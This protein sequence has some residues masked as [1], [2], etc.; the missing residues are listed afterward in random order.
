[1]MNIKFTLKQHILLLL[2][3]GKR[4]LLLLL[5]LLLPLLLLVCFGSPEMKILIGTAPLWLWILIGGGIMLLITT[6]IVD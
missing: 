4:P 6:L 2:W 3:R 1:M 5:S